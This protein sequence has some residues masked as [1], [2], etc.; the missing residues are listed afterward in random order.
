MIQRGRP[1]SKGKWAFPSGFI[2]LGETPEEAALREREEESGVTGEILDLIGVYHE[3]SEVWGDILVIMYLVNVTGGEV[4]AG[5]DA[6]DARLFLKGE[7]PRFKFMSFRHSWER[8]QQMIG[9]RHIP[10]D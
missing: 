5:D 1:P 8:A 4:R 3:N 6:V 7:I 10:L 9:E 2:E